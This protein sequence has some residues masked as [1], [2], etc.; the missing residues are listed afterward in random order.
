MRILLTA[1]RAL[2]APVI[3]R[4]F[5]RYGHEV[6]TADSMRFGAGNSC[7][8]R[9]K[10]IRVP[11][12]RFFES[13]FVHAINNIVKKEQINLIL[14]L[15]EEG[16]Y[17][18]KHRV[19]LL[20]ECFVGDIEKIELLHDKMAFYSLCMKLG[21]KAPHT[22]IAK[23]A[24]ENKIYK[25]IFSRC[26]ESTTLN[27][28]NIDFSGGEWLAQNFIKGTPIS[29]FSVGANTL[30]YGARFYNK[31][32]PFSNI[33]VI[34]DNELKQQAEDIVSKIRAH[35][36]YQGVMGMD[37]ILADNEELF[38]IECNPRITSALLFMDKYNLLNI[39]LKQSNSVEIKDETRKFI[40]Y[41]FW[42][43]LIGGVNPPNIKAYISAMLRFEESVFN[44][45][46]VKPFLASYM[47]N[48]E[49]MYIARKNKITVQ[50]AASYD[51]QYNQSN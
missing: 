18:A 48:L 2:I 7:N 45:Y 51:I 43:F 6:I 35:T 1:S 44:I 5:A 31:I 49:W 19:E 13:D 4:N 47:M 14:P 3:I 24:G 17:L 36:G 8:K 30:V 29:S 23:R 41:M 9:V 28:Q 32:E 33:Y 10:H 37:F 25:R 15:G 34:N 16:Y 50:E 39:L 26:G 12:C 42:Q 20:C 27:P 22:E 38:C 40:G 46:D 21:I 11:S